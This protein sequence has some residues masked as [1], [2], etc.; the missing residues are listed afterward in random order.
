[1]LPFLFIVIEIFLI[2]GKGVIFGQYS[3]ANGKI[4]LGWGNSLSDTLWLSVYDGYT[5]NGDETETESLQKKYGQKDGINIDYVD[6]TRKISSSINNDWYFGNT[7]AVGAGINN[8]FGV[9]AVWT[10]DYYNYKD[11]PYTFDATTGKWNIG[12]LPT[13]IKSES[14]D[15]SAGTTT[16]EEYTNIKNYNNY[17]T[18]RFNFKGV[19]IE[20]DG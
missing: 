3:S 19:G 6:E 11:H 17:N 4:E 8:T 10:A 5:M 1:M 20:N 16:S 14:A 15:S 12:I 9:Q 2:E 7:L 18:I 13:S